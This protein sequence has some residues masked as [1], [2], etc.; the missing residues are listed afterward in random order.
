MRSLLTSRAFSHI[1]RQFEENELPE[2][3]CEEEDL[4]NATVDGMSMAEKMAMWNI[5]EEGRWDIAEE[6]STRPELKEENQYLEDTILPPRYQE[7]RSFLLNGPAYTWL[8]KNIQSSALLTHTTGTT[9]ESFSRPIADIMSSMRP[10]SPHAQTFQ[11]TFEMDWD[12][13]GF[14]RHQRYDTTLEIAIE[15]AIILTG[16]HV[17]AQAL[18]CLEYMCQTWPSTGSEMLRALQNALSQ[19]D[20]SSSSESINNDILF[21]VPR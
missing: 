19:Q 9:E 13:P 2:H 8:L 20:L 18:S 6:G 12:L 7:V 15:S 4:S 3:H 17:N 16:S 5:D 10:K 1:I 11:A 14:L 21:R